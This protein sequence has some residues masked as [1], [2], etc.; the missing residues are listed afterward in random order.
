[1]ILRSIY[2]NLERRDY[3]NEFG[4]RF[5]CR[6]RCLCNF[7]G[8]LL[9]SKS[10]KTEGFNRIVIVGARDRTSTVI[11]NSCSV[12]SV[13]LPFDEARYRELDGDA[14][15]EFFIGM[16]RDGLTFFATEHRMVAD[17][18]HEGIELFRAS[19]Y[20]NEW[21]HK[22]RMFRH[23]GLTAALQCQLTL[24]RFSLT[25]VVR[26]RGREV[27]CREILSTDSDEVAFDYRF[28]DVAIE[29]GKLVVLSKTSEPLLALELAPLLKGDAK[30]PTNRDDSC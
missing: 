18:I 22:N 25:L 30:S 6:S 1:M 5:M 19:R 14:L 4:Y 29:D 20:R 7:L 16:L 9:K 2:L 8:R 23:L 12:A 11:V 17:A 28:R 10:I 3:P 13:A 21:T 27:L 24:E 26:S 15:Q